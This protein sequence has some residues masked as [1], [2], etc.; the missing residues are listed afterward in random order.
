[1][2]FLTLLLLL[3]FLKKLETFLIKRK[4]C[5]TALS[6]Q[7]IL[8]ACFC[9]LVFCWFCVMYNAKCIGNNLGAGTLMYAT[10]RERNVVVQ[11]PAATEDDVS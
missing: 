5:V 8:N 10:E 9:L 4:L 7:L 6:F 3:S 11:K 2:P 1:M